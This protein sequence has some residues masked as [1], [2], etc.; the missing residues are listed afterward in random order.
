[1][2]IGERLRRLVSRYRWWRF[3]KALERYTAATR[4]AAAAMTVLTRPDT[5]GEQHA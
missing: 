1:M 4:R 3:R 5:E 2:S